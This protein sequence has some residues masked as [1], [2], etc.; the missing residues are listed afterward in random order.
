MYACVLAA[1]GVHVSMLSG[2][3]CLRNK[4]PSSGGA[5]RGRRPPAPPIAML[6]HDKGGSWGLRKKR[7]SLR[8]SRFS[9]EHSTLSLGVRGVSLALG[10]FGAMGVYFADTGNRF[11]AWKRFHASARCSL[12]DSARARYLLRQDAPCIPHRVAHRGFSDQRP[13]GGRVAGRAGRRRAAGQAA[14]RRNECAE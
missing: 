11:T 9:A 7:P 2:N 12:Q 4:R 1:F 14:G 13:A 10:C 6:S 5:R 3:R 8:D